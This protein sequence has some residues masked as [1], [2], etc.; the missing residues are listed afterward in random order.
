MDQQIMTEEE[1]LALITSMIRKAKCDY[2]ESGISALM[3]GSVI[4]FCSLID[5]IS[6]FQKWEW[7]NYIWFLPLIVVI[8]QIIIGIREGRK[9]KI[10]SY[11]DD[12][13]SGIWIS[14]GISI[15][16]FSYFNSRYPVTHVESAYIILYGIPTF[17]TGMVRRFFPMTLGGIA[18]WIIAII[19]I[20]VNFPYTMLLTALA[21]I[22]A[23][24]IPGLILRSRYL[25]LMKENV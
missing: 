3:W 23:W 1:S 7:A 11:H 15:L 17:T 8:P 6:Y 9:K 5:F 19:T 12:T 13:M 2:E 24:F 10:K 18:C 20:Y 21:A 16:L 22:V 4:T 25:K 14:F